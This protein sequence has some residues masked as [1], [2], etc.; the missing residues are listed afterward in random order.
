MHYEGNAVL[1]QGT[2]RIQSDI[3]DIDRDKR[4]LIVA[5]GKVVTQMIDKQKERHAPKDAVLCPSRS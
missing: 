3:I 5:S 2:D 1:W 4:T